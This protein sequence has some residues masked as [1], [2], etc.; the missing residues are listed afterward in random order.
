MVQSNP[1][2]RKLEEFLQN[3]KYKTVWE[4]PLMFL[5]GLQAIKTLAYHNYKS[6][7]TLM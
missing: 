5:I 3:L 7:T 1:G 4:T 6:K 2:I